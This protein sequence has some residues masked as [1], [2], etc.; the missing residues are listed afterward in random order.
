MAG[1]EH[2]QRLAEERI[3]N[4]EAQAFQDPEAEEVPPERKPVAEA[5]TALQE[6]RQLDEVK[7]IGRL[8]RRKNQKT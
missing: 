4:R 8:E 3:S 6:L 2:H 5:M 7:R 1:A